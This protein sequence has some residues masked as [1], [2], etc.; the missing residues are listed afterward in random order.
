MCLLVSNV[1]IQQRFD[2]YRGL[3]TGLAVIG[4]SLG[5]I[6]GPPLVEYL[7][8]HYLVRGTLALLGAIQAHRLPLAFQFHTPPELLV[9]RPPSTQQ[10]LQQVSFY[11]SKIILRQYNTLLVT[12]FYDGFPLI[13]TVLK[14]LGVDRGQAFKL[15]VVARGRSQYK[16]N[17]CA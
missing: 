8:K 16:F 10:P 2:R 13:L 3:A 4:F 6:T 5:N 11:V 7:L 17:T 1:I 15:T 9:R 14:H 12:F